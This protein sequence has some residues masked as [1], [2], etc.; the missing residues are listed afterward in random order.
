MLVTGLLASPP[1]LGGSAT[2]QQVETAKRVSELKTRV[3]ELAARAQFGEAGPLLGEAVD[4]ARIEPLQPNRA[5]GTDLIAIASALMPTKQYRSL[6]YLFKRGIAI[7]QA[8]PDA[9]LG[10]VMVAL[11]NLSALYD[12]AGA[13]SARDQ[14]MAS[15]VNA[16]ENLQQP[17]DADTVGVF[18]ELGRLYS[19]AKQYE[20]VAILYKRVH[21]YMLHHYE[22]D[23]KTLALWTWKYAGILVHDGKSSKATELRA[24]ALALVEHST[25]VVAKSRMDLLLQMYTVANS[26]GD[27]D[28]QKE[29]LERARTAAEQGGFEQ[30]AEAAAIYHNLAVLYLGQGGIENYLEAERL[31]R[32]SLDIETGMG[33]TATVG[34]AQGLNQLAV[35]LNLAG[36][37]EEAELYYGKAI[38]AF[39]GLPSP[40]PLQFSRCLED[41]GI[42]LIEQGRAAEAAAIFGRAI[43]QVEQNPDTAFANLVSAQAN[44]YFKSGEFDEASHA[45]WRAIQLRQAA[46]KAP[47]RTESEQSPQ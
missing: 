27:V 31:L 23:P 17:I 9:R 1:F 4:L 34:F 40:E 44:A 32:R 39:E 37:A 38:R 2:A 13:S 10:D 33:R 43:A 24:E 8:S 21:E 29:A 18:L 47:K 5:L 15:I 35:V 41:L 14:V 28:A 36:K 25:P 22:A 16:A 3:N 12:A 26:E 11:N 20:P 7:L 45:Y 19:N 46:P 42:M 6:E 30:T